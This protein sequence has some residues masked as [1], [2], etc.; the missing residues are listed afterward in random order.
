VGKQSTTYSY[1]EACAL[2]IASFETFSDRLA[3]FAR[4]CIEERWIDAEPRLGK[5][6]GGFC[7]DLPSVQES[8]ILMNFDGSL[9]ATSTLAH[10]IGHAF[11]NECHYRAGMGPLQSST[12]MTLAETASIMCE[13]ILLDHIL[14]HGLDEEEELAVLETGLIS[15]SQVI[16][17]IYSR[18][19]FEREVYS[20]RAHAELSAEEFNTLMED[21]QRRAYGTA[22][23]ERFLQKFMWTWKPHYYSPNLGFYNF[24]YSFGLLFAKGLYAAYRRRGPSFVP[25]YESLLASTGTASAAD[26][27]GRFGI[28]IRTKKF[29]SDS[30]ALVGERISRYERLARR[31]TRGR[32]SKRK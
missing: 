19:L 28:D 10:E 27:A 17:D 20:R 26:L 9:D 32:K 11:H 8:R 6:G 3:E 15:E 16:V 22:L 12:P 7:M 31:R 23:D 24:P 29:W 25:E 14:R 30:L 5:R 2:V 21:A 18:F 1:R 4:R 13:Q